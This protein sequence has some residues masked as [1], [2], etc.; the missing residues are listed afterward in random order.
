MVNVENLKLYEPTLIM[1]QGENIQVPFVE[2]FSPEYLDESW[3]YFIL[4]RKVRTSRRGDVE[5]LH[6]GLKGMHPSKT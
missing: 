6:V 3:E 4:D 2:Y 5:Y 1:D